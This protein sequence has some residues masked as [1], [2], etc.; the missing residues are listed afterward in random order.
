MD[1]VPSGLRFL[2]GA[3]GDSNPYKFL[4]KQAL[5]WAECGMAVLR[6]IP[7]SCIC[8]AVLRGVTVLRTRLH[9]RTRR[10]RV[11]GRWIPVAEP[12]GL[13]RP[14]KELNSV[15]LLT[16]RR[17][18]SH[19]NTNRSPPPTQATSGH[20][21]TLASFSITS[22]P[23]DCAGASRRHCSGCAAGGWL[24]HSSAS[25]HKVDYVISPSGLLA[26]YS[27]AD[28]YSRAF[29]FNQ[30]SAQILSTGPAIYRSNDGKGDH[31]DSHDD[32]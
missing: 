19:T 10:S 24:G 12:H 27:A 17:I 9:R 32:H 22:Q 1:G 8:P 23:N 6:R 21:S 14:L 5:N 29:S 16:P 15:R 25:I 2:C 4:H 18:V 3:K 26:R 20:P 13:T 31:N 28:V 11:K 30:R 7:A